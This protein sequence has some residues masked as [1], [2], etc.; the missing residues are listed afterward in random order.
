VKRSI[1]SNQVVDSIFKLRSIHA[2]EVTSKWQRTIGRY[3]GGTRET[4]L[5][6]DGS[7]VRR[8]QGIIENGIQQDGTGQGRTYWEYKRT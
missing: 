2:R 3:F 5:L 7:H 1:E 4:E 8:S 6:S